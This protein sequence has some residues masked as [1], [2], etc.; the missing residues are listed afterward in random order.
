MA[1]KGR[2]RR[3]VATKATAVIRQKASQ[4]TNGQATGVWLTNP[5]RGGA[6]DMNNP[7][8]NKRLLWKKEKTK[9]AKCRR[10]GRQDPTGRHQLGRYDRWPT[11]HV[12]TSPPSPAARS[13]AVLGVVGGQGPRAQAVRPQHCHPSLARRRV[14]WPSLAT[15]RRQRCAPTLIR[16][17]PRETCRGRGAGRNNTGTEPRGPRR[18]LSPPGCSRGEAAPGAR[19]ST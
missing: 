6:G 10:H 8:A 2:P 5:Q 18:R 14:P 3:H 7:P 9:N 13:R 4:R 11:P 12:A 16:R 19:A 1:H 15:T 17:Q